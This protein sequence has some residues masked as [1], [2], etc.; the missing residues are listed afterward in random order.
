MMAWIL[1]FAGRPEDGLKAIDLAER[2]N[3]RFPSVY[4]LVKASNLYAVEAYHEAVN[5]LE[6]ASD[7]SPHHPLIRLWLAAAYAATGK[8]PD[9]EWQVEELTAQNPNM[10]LRYIKAICP[11]KDPAHLARFT[12][13]L[14]Q[15][16][17]SD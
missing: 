5:I 10:S 9:A 13:H 12:G 4:R 7:I 14:K 11:F 6:V 8:V 2:L 15:A 3:P 16:G 1:Y 17:L